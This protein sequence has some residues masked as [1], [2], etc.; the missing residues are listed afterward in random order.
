MLTITNPEV[1]H[2]LRDLP[3]GL[4]PTRTA[5]TSRLTL[6]VKSM[7]E[8]AVTA[9]LRRFFRFYLIPLRAGEI[10]TQ[11]LLTAFFD[12][13]DEPL[14]IRTPLFDEKFTRDVLEVLSSDSLDVH[15]FDEHNREL[16]AF[17]AKNPGA[18]RFRSIANT[19]HF[20]TPTLA[21]ARQFHDDMPI[22]FGA[23][24]AADDK[25]ALT[26]NLMESLFPHNLHLQSQNPGAFNERDIA[27]SLHRP[28]GRNHVYRNPVRADNGRE[29]VDVL[30]AT[31]KTVLL[32]QAKDSPDTES[33]LSRSIGRKKATAAAHIRKAAAQ[34]K[35]SINY[36]RS[37]SSVEVITD[38]QRGGV[39]M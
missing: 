26:I 20:V 16:L 12:D 35:G 24:S 27:M 5:G 2:A 8:V 34:L 31:E 29:F 13:H 6:I 7:R 15:F 30:V 14:T 11:G 28:F 18:K 21:L 25:A 33:T 4:L 22:R 3:G 39:S 19:M 38:G 36:L 10:E 1:L 32:I 17:R 23:R 9:H 37:N